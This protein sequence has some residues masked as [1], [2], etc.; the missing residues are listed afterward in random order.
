MILDHQPSFSASQAR[1]LAAEH[2]GIEAR[3]SPL[4]SDRDQNFLLETEDR[5]RF[6]LKI[7]N[8]SASS[9]RIHFENQVIRTVGATIEP[10]SMPGPIRGIAGSDIVGV[11]ANGRTY[12]TRVLTWV[13]GKQLAF[14]Q[15]HTPDLFAQIGMCLGRLSAALRPLEEVGSTTSPEWDLRQVEQTVAEH[16]RFVTDAARLEIID[17]H[18]DRFTARTKPLL[19]ALPQQVVFNDANDHNILVSADRRGFPRISGLIDF[20][21]AAVCYRI[22][23]LAIAS[24]YAMMD[25]PDPIGAAR[26][27]ASGFSSACPIL[28]VEADALFDLICM[29]LCTSVVLSAMRSDREPDNDYVTVSQQPA[30]D[31][32]ERLRNVD[33]NFAR[34]SLRDACGFEPNPAALQIRQ[35]LASHAGRFQSVCDRDLKS[36]NLTVFDLSTGSR[37]PITLADEPIAT[38]RLF[39]RLNRD[40]SAA[41]IGRY[42]E[43]RLVYSAPRFAVESWTGVQ[44]RTVH[45]GIDIFQEAGRPVFAPLAGRVH[46]ARAQNEP[47]GYGHLV[48]LQHSP[49]GCPPF[50]TLYGHL[51]SES[52]DRIQPGDVLQ[53]GDL[54][55]YLGRPSENGGWTPHLHFQIVT[56]L[57]DLEADFH[58]VARSDERA[59]WLSICPDPNLILEIPAGLLTREDLSTEQILEKRTALLGPSLSLSYDEPLHIVRGVGARLYD[60]TGRGFLDCVNNVCH[61]G[62]SHPKV[63]EAATNQMRVLNTNTRYLHENLIRYA[64]RLTETLPEPLDTCYFV[65]SGSEANDLAIR[66]ATQHTGRRGIVVLDGAYHGNLSSLIRLSPYKFDGPGGSGRSDGVYVAEMPDTYRGRFRGEKAMAAYSADFEARVNEA[67]RS[68]GAAAFLFESILGCGGQIDPPSGYFES[69]CSLA[70]QSGML[71]IADEVQVGFGRVGDAFWG[72]E[73]HGIVPDIVTMGKPIGNGH[74]IGAV[75][76]TRAIAESFANGME[77]FNTFGGNPVSCAVGLAVL[78]VIEEEGLQSHALAV[79]SRLKRKLSDLARKHPTIGDVRGSGLFLGIELVRDRESREPAPIV[80]SYVAQRARQLGVLLSTDGPQHNVIKIKPPIVFSDSDADELIRV[81]DRVLAEVPSKG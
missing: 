31:I 18:L 46:Y 8:S 21:D 71:C 24:A 9:E 79:G 44:N 5:Q 23:D 36:E 6:V 30:W 16:R 63:V 47:Y 2:F 26:S 34:F 43:A 35:W 59:I 39:D 3:A 17:D 80:A 45:L 67:M 57:L 62:H 66:L 69:T 29:R 11:E 61:V 65:N 38:R 28:E 54:V 27:V 78:D 60:E 48:I 19:N 55:G 15:P 41:G 37:D 75:V 20:G 4:P 81:V 33:P 52:L 10:V 53:P 22:A 32:L 13:E 72:F 73:H 64:E 40:R 51:S 50:Y 70:R 76:T 7:A 68:G 58:G 42:N 77:Y 74:P 49:E 14:A 1:L 12:Q 56:D 25:K